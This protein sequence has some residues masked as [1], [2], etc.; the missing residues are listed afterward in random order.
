MYIKKIFIRR[1]SSV[2]IV[3]SLSSSSARPD[4]PSVLCQHLPIPIYLFILFFLMET[5]FAG[6][7]KY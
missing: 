6:L 7:I 5:C 2:H 1:V 3:L 4:S